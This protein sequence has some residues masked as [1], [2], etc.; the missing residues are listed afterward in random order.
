[1][2]TG[3]RLVSDRREGSWMDGLGGVGGLS[4]GGA[5]TGSQPECCHGEM[6]AQYPQD[7][8]LW[9]RGWKLK[10]LCEIS[11]SARVN[12]ENLAIGQTSLGAAKSLSRVWLYMILWT[13]VR[14]TPQSMGFSRQEYWSGLPFPLPG[15]LP[16]P[17]IKLTSHISFIGRQVLYHWHHLERPGLRAYCL[18]T[19]GGAWKLSE[20][21]QNVTW[22]GQDLHLASHP[23]HGC[24]FGL[25]SWFWR[26]GTGWATICPFKSPHPS[27]SEYDCIWRQNL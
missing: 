18:H 3:A 11:R 10:Y 9:K 12:Q 23:P 21:H 8:Q 5:T 7:L 4:E 13:V 20:E 1:M 2:I 22:G 25:T 14:K 26:L 24:E 19:G 6:Q 27:A 16:D 15:D 17:G